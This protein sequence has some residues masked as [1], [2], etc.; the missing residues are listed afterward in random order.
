MP[1][2][3]GS[4]R[5]SNDSS[6]VGA[7]GSQ[8]AFKQEKLRHSEGAQALVLLRF[9]GR[10]EC[11]LGPGDFEAC[12][13]QVWAERPLL[14]LKSQL[15]HRSFH[16]AD[17]F[18]KIRRSLDSRPKHSRAAR[19][20]EEAKPLC[21]QREFFELT[22]ILQSLGDLS[23]LVGGDLPQKLQ[24]HVNALGLCPSAIGTDGA[25]GS[26]LAVK[27]RPDFFGQVDGDKGSHIGTMKRKVN[28]GRS[29]SLVSGK[30]LRFLLPSHQS[31]TLR[32]IISK[33]ALVDQRR[34]RSRSP[35]KRNSRTCVLRSSAKPMK[36]RPTGFSAVPPVGPAMPVMPMPIEADIRART[37]SASA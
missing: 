28:A 29:I 7:L 18:Q 32:R 25:K 36:T 22:Q 35:G 1:P 6:I 21:F 10:P 23:H 17:E 15:F 20:G 34:T 26:L 14:A 9:G 27:C 2:L 33:A 11:G 19:I 37:P 13:G 3:V 30:V 24:G 4:T 5:K 12:K 31:L 16:T 8:P